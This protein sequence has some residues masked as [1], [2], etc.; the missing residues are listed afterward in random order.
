LP[1]QLLCLAILP[2]NPKASSPSLSPRLSFPCAQHLPLVL[3]KRSRKATIP[4]RITSFAH[5]HQL[6]TIESYLYKNRGRGW[7][8]SL[9]DRFPNAFLHSA[10]AYQISDEEICPDDR[11]EE[12]SLSTSDQG[13]VSRASGV[14]DLSPRPTRKSVLT[15]EPRKDLSLNP[16]KDFSPERRTEAGR[17]FW[18]GFVNYSAS[19]FDRVTLATRQT[20]AVEASSWGD[21]VV[22]L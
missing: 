12:G 5:P 10:T 17:F 19:K 15:S 22:K 16:T 11:S 8:P 9:P 21:C 20:L 1:P 4:F 18:A 7:G 13:L 6:T 3:P 14:R 2:T